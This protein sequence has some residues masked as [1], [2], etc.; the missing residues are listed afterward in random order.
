MAAVDSKSV[1]G[2]D[3]DASV[4]SVHKPVEI[5]KINR[6]VEF[7]GFKMQ[8]SIKIY[9]YIM[10]KFRG[11]GKRFVGFESPGWWDRCVAIGRC[12]MCRRMV[13]ARG[14]EPLTR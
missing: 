12:G 7:H 6:D 11:A 14:L 9:F 4:E 13:G 1:A 10:D 8:C 2:C 3:G 5:A